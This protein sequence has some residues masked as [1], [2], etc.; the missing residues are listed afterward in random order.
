MWTPERQAR[1][2]ATVPTVLRGYLADISCREQELVEPLLPGKARTG[3]TR[4]TELRQVINAW[5]YLVR[6]G[7]EWRML[8]IDFP[9]YLT[10]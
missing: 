8:P 7:H 3:R 5:R 6:S 9:P 2:E 4:M 10:M 1:H